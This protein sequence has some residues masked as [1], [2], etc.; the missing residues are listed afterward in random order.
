MEV[1]VEAV[2][3]FNVEQDVE[4]RNISFEKETDKEAFDRLLQEN[5]RKNEHFSLYLFP[6]ANKCQINMWNRSDKKQTILGDLL[7]CS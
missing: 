7:E 6:F 4:I 5:L 3:R 2:P 1:V